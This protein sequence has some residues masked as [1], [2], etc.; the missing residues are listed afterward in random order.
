MSPSD[1][2]GENHWHINTLETHTTHAQGQLNTINGFKGTPS[3]NYTLR[4]GHNNKPPELSNCVC[5]AN[6]NEITYL[7]TKLI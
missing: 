6:N 7:Q 3:T 5:V 1:G 2:L 4:F